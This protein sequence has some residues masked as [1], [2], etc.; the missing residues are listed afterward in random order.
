MH[1]ALV[2]LN[3]ESSL[4]SSTSDPIPVERVSES[5]RSSSRVTVDLVSE[6]E[7]RKGLMNLLNH[8]LEDRS[9]D[10]KTKYGYLM[11]VTFTYLKVIYLILSLVIIGRSTG[12]QLPQKS[13]QLLSMG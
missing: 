9:L 4:S 2:R 1:S 10:P 11:Q 7:T 13:V 3:I 12:L 5:G 6:L 8:I